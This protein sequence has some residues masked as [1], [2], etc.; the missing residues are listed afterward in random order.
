[1]LV[2]YPT[3]NIAPPETSILALELIALV[4]LLSLNVPLLILVLSPIM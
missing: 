3:I 2:L 1:M 4:A